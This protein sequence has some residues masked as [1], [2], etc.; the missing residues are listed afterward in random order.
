MRARR[1]ILPLSSPSAGPGQI[2]G[3]IVLGFDEPRELNEPTMAVINQIIG[4]GEVG[5]EREVL[6]RTTDLERVAWHTRLPRQPHRAVQPRIAGGLTLQ[7]RLAIDDVR[8]PSQVAVLMLDVDRFE[9]IND[10]LGH[11]QGDQVLRAVAQDITHSVRPEDLV[12]RFVGEEFLIMLSG[13]DAL[14]RAKL[15]GA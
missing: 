12:F 7:H 8:S 4:L 10:T 14:Y 3:A 11:L 15:K 13:V 1:L 2:D 5:L 9:V 6:L